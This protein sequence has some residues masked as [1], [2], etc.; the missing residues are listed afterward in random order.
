MI[1]I[2]TACP[3]LII[4][5]NKKITRTQRGESSSTNS[6]AAL[7]Y[8][9]LSRGCKKDRLNYGYS[10]IMKFNCFRLFQSVTM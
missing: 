1:A 2:V 6:E 9:V 4:T 3:V 5:L 10:L 8:R 7:K